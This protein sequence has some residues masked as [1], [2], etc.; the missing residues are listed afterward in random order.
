MNTSDSKE[1]T[2]ETNPNPNHSLIRFDKNLAASGVD[3]HQS[4]GPDGQLIF[5]LIFYICHTYQKD[6]FGYGTIDPVEFAKVMGY[7]RANLF[8]Q[9]QDP[10]QFKNDKLLRREFEKIKENGKYDV[11][12]SN[13]DYPMHTVLDNALYRALKENLVFSKVRKDFSKN[14][15]VMEMEAINL[16]SGLKKYYKEGNKKISYSLKLSSTIEEHLNKYFMIGNTASIIAMRKKNGVA[17]YMYLK[18]MKDSI[19]NS[20]KKVATPNF[21]YICKM[22]MINSIDAKDRKKYLKRKL[23]EVLKNT[24]INFTYRFEKCNGR[25]DYNIV[26]EFLEDTIFIEKADIYKEL[27]YDQYKHQLKSYFD[28]LKSPSIWESWLTDNSKDLHIKFNTLLQITMDVTKSPKYDPKTQLRICNFFK[29]DTK[30][31]NSLLER[32]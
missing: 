19:Q 25:W 20:A 26:I 13:G 7:K 11:A 9:H 24:E 29:I 12:L 1:I 14:E 4:Y 18:N 2:K 30:T 10:A 17:L 23:E 32:F 22:A 8:K 6:L 21:D 15:T 16:I 28:K 3:F 5:D 31:Y 27:I